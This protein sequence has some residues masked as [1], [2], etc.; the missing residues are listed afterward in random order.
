LEVVK[1]RL[2]SSNS[3]F[4][5]GGGGKHGEGTVSHFKTIVAAQRSLDESRSS[6][7]DFK[8]ATFCLMI[9]IKVGFYRVLFAQD[10]LLCP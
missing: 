10:V 9:L 4:E 1:T 6:Q 5:G 2:Q 3:G 7:V 8:D